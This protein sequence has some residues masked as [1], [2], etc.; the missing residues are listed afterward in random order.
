ME[1]G[2][3]ALTVGESR[4]CFVERRKE[5]RRLMLL[6]AVLAAMML[7]AS[8]VSAFVWKPGP[9]EGNKYS[10]NYYPNG[11]FKYCE[12]DGSNYSQTKASKN[13]WCDKYYKEYTKKTFNG[14]NWYSVHVYYSWKTPDGKTHKWD[15]WYYCAYHKYDDPHSK[16]P[17]FRAWV[18]YKPTGNAY[19]ESF[20]YWNSP[21][22]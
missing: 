22:H 12:P 18:T 21:T 5:L 1:R 9:N 8:P 2:S 7:V 11:Y 16:K 4:N 20:Y 6:L 14:K 19:W 10:K 15:D 13:S 17:Y 3:L